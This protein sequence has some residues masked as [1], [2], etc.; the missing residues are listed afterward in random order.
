MLG[1]LMSRS[2]F[3]ETIMS[4]KAKQDAGP[5]LIR[6]W[7]ERRRDVIWISPTLYQL[8]TAAPFA[9][10]LRPG[11]RLGADDPARVYCASAPRSCRRSKRRKKIV[12]CAAS[13]K[14]ERGKLDRKALAAEWS[15]SRG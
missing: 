5:D 9:A 11:A 1:R 2:Q 4:Q 12:L 14:S 3:R 10:L 8:R 15:R 6:K 7:I 13:P